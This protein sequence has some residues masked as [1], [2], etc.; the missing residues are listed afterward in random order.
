MAG[1]R[2]ASASSWATRA[3]LQR[4]QIHQCSSPPQLRPRRVQFAIAKPVHLRRVVPG[5]PQVGPDARPQLPRAV[6]FRDVVVSADLQSNHF[7]RLLSPRRQHQNR[8]PHAPLPQVPAH[9]KPVPLGQ[10]HVQQDQVVPPLRAR[11]ACRF[12]IHHQRRVVA[13]PPQVV[14]QRQR[15]A[16]FI[17]DDK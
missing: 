3:G 17:F 11:L 8:R 15:D 6:R 9:F 10:H 1:R 13:L 7:L 4:L 2:S 12:A 16:G 5:P 14:F